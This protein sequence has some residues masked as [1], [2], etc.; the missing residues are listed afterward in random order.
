MLISRHFLNL[1][2]FYT[3]FMQFC[4]ILCNFM[5]F[6]A[7]LCHF[8]PFCAILCHFVPFYVILCHFMPFFDKPQIPILYFYA[9]SHTF[10][11]MQGFNVLN[12]DSQDS[13]LPA[14]IPLYSNEDFNFQG[15]WHLLGKTQSVHKVLIMIPRHTQSPQPV[16]PNRPECLSLQAFIASVM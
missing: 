7:I 12:Y 11:S 3:M 5:P 6:C 9:F 16:E 14:N 15:L 8:V 1:C 4:A 13:Q 10:L 2:N